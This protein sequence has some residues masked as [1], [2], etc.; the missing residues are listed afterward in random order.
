M[1]G[2]AAG[3]GALS[4]QQPDCGERATL[5]IAV[6]ND[7]GGAPVRNG[8]V[9]V[10]WTEAERARRPLR[11]E[12]RAGGRLVLCAPQDAEQAT[13][14]AE[15]GDVSSE[16]AV[17]LIVAG[18]SHDITLTLRPAEIRTG[19][20][21]GEVLD[22]VTDDPVVAAVVSV[23]DRLRVA[24]TNRRGRFVLSGVPVGMQEL[25]VR[26]LGYA[27][28]T[29]VVEVSSG[30]TTEVEI[31]MVPDP[32]E[33]E[34]IVA[35]VIRSR[36]LEVKGFYERRH[37][38]ELVGTGTYYTA[39]DIDRRRPVEIS[40]MV[41]DESGIRLQCNIR[42]TDC[43]LVNTRLSSGVTGACSL[44][45]YVDGLPTR[46]IPL[47]DVVRPSEIAGLEIYKGLASGPAEFPPSRCGL[48]VV[49][50]K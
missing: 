24:E 4:A 27:P 6:L 33:M 41:A 25:N 36:R 40:H 39:E 16:E 30:L 15:W 37:W 20:L 47:D 29:Y 45:F 13:L 1:F 2:L 5:R 12:V 7:Y 38:G 23:P 17:V 42:R 49:W 10:R 35:T 22:A 26:H 19:R 48:I 46:G 11:E 50:T 3:A 8:A 28:L 31:G 32:V 21:V 44:N 34:P 9:V 14:W 43:R 18:M